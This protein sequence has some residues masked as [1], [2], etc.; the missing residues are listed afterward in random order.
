L[1]L[2]NINLVLIFVELTL[3]YP[4][5][6]LEFELKGLDLYLSNLSLNG[7]LFNELFKL[8]CLRLF[9]TTSTSD[10][11]SNSLDRF[12]LLVLALV[13]LNRDLFKELLLMLLVY[14]LSTIDKFEFDC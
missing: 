6:Y 13:N 1:P 12:K 8:T 7:D 11:K 9:L 4:L 3:A 10:L 2:L 14:R 5:S